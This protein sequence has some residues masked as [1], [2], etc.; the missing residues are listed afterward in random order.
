MPIQV[1][2]SVLDATFY[3]SIP[4]ETTDTYH[5]FDKISICNHYGLFRRMTGVGGR[6]EVIIEGSNSLDH[7]WKEYEFFYKPGDVS[8]PPPFICEFFVLLF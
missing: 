1:P 7:N 3:H 5:I 6:P 4:R 8:K 2:L